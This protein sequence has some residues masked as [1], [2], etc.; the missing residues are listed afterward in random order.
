[1]LLMTRTAYAKRRNVN[2]K[3][4]ARW[5]QQGL[6]AMEG[7]KINVEKTDALLEKFHPT[8][9]VIDH[10]ERTTALSQLK[11]EKLSL[12]IKMK[13][14][15]L[16]IKT[17]LVIS[18]SE[19]NDALG[20]ELNVVRNLLLS[21]P[22]KLAPRLSGSNRTTAQVKSLLDSE[23]T[24]ILSEIHADEDYAVLAAKHDEDTALAVFEYWEDLTET[25][26]IKTDEQTSLSDLKRLNIEAD[27][28]TLRQKIRDKL[29][30]L[31]PVIHIAT[32][33]HT[34]CDRIRREVKRLS[35]KVSPKL[36]GTVL[37]PTRIKSIIDT[38]VHNVF[39][40]IAAGSVI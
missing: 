9:G 4:I 14:L 39:D 3:T 28:Q 35:G 5:K 8:G 20:P 2:E 33:M 36:S 6:I 23:L 19:S 17:G 31:I 12:E 30:D 16:D 11:S 13:R 34:E 10:G 40:A 27:I 22:A 26:P 32:G 18:S 15:L 38:E 24:L 29:K 7:L 1:M 21:L 37:A 25:E